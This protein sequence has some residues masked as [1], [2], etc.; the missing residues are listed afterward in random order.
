MADILNPSNYS[1]PLFNPS[2]VLQGA[3]NTFGRL[4]NEIVIPGNDDWKP[5][6]LGLFI[7]PAIILVLF[8]IGCF[9]MCLSRCKPFR[10]KHRYEE[11]GRTI[12][13][14]AFLAFIVGLLDR[15]SAGVL[16]SMG[17]AYLLKESTPSMPH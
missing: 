6:W 11:K 8:F 12:G 10:C 4:S 9:G 5:Y 17:G 1:A 13:F 7:L 2:S 3:H 14:F 15:S 16:Y